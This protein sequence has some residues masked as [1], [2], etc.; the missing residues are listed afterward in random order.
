MSLC[1]C[2]CVG[3]C[4]CV[5]ETPVP[6]DVMNRILVF[7]EMQGAAGL[8]SELRPTKTSDGRCENV[9]AEMTI[10]FEVTSNEKK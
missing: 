9:P 1:A 6:K 2:G 7:R 10:S 8:P 3:V 4:V 5:C